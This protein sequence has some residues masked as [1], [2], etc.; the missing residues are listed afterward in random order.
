ML[1]EHLPEELDKFIRDTELGWY[2][3]L[4]DRLSN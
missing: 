3:E 2:E 1:Y 4:I